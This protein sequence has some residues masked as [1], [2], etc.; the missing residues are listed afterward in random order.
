MMSSNIISDPGFIPVILQ[1]KS[2][3]K[4]GLGLPSDPTKKNAFLADLSKFLH[5]FFKK[6]EKDN[7]DPGFEYVGLLEYTADKQ[8]YMLYFLPKYYDMA[9]VK[10]AKE[11]LDKTAPVYKHFS[12][13]LKTINKYRLEKSHSAIKENRLQTQLEQETETADHNSKLAVAVTLIEDYLE[14]GVYTNM[15][16]RRSLC[17]NGEIDWQH[18]INTVDPVIRDEAPYYFDYWTADRI[19]NTETLI[20]R[21]HEAIIKD[22]SISLA[23]WGLD[24]L[25][26]L[27]TPMPYE[28]EL[29]D[30]GDK[31][32]IVAIINQELSVQFITQK[33]N[34]LKLMR[35]Y[36]EL[37]NT[38]ITEG[39]SM[40]GTGSF[41]AVWEKVCGTVFGNQLYEPIDDE[42]LPDEMKGKQINKWSDIEARAKWRIDGGAEIDEEAPDEKDASKLRPDFVALD[43]KK[44]I[45]YI[46]DAKYY[47]PTFSDRSV[48]GCPGVG[49]VNK[50]HLYQLTYHPLIKEN[51]WQVVNA[52]LMP[53]S[54]KNFQD[55][56]KA[57]KSYCSIFKDI[58]ITHSKDGVSNDG[59]EFSF[60]EIQTL[61][62]E[63]EKLFGY[64]L[65][66]NSGLLENEM[67]TLKPQVVIRQN[68]KK[69]CRA[70][71]ARWKTIPDLL[72]K[73]RRSENILRCYRKDF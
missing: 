22:C 28:G 8:N 52:F 57:V 43:E 31:D 50:Q 55:T 14:N 63:P 21:L 20:A 37:E 1:E 17:G 2:K 27:E 66:G 24:E 44:N 6:N 29:S 71:F 34:L 38:S 40:F 65:D 72:R 58:R 62:L 48:N 5:K 60:A 23:Q 64:Y 68:C 12:L 18:T 42:L 53:K 15:K 59:V 19:V 61:F 67:L 13:V 16:N 9:Q 39:V 4:N 10:S 51:N 73:H 49:D 70:V 47:V 33:Q 45:L 69:F 3:L 41:H 25:L 7:T 36:I 30:F 54:C 35:T 46:L 56:E 11:I 26:E 32:G